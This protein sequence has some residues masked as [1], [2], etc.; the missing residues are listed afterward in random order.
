MNRQGLEEILR[1]RPAALTSLP[2][3]Q[4]NLKDRAMTN[5]FATTLDLNSDIYEIGLI[6]A[7]SPDFTDALIRALVVAGRDTHASK[8]PGDSAFVT[9]VV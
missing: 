1:L 4:D 9:N 2:E 5:Q 7:A 8:E 3:L 6:A